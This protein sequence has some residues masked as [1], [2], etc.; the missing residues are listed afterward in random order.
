MVAPMRFL[1]EQ[2]QPWSCACCLFHSNLEP[3]EFSMRLA[4]LAAVPLLA[5]TP[6]L[7]APDYSVYPDSAPTDSTVVV[8]PRADSTT[9]I[10]TPLHPSEDRQIAANA[11]RESYYRNKLE[12]AQAQARM[13]SA[14]ANREAAAAER[15]AAQDRAA[16]DREAAE[17]AE[18]N[19]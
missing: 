1:L 8:T 5:A 4:M 11:A 10:V 2:S 14:E 16:V 6:A 13:D 18:A 19:R 3:K 7:A 12:A 9:T 15:D 17:D